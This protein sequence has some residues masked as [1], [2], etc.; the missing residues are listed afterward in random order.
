MRDARSS[1][2]W[3]ATGLLL[4]IAVVALFHFGVIVALRLSNSSSSTDMQSSSAALVQLHRHLGDPGDAW[5]EPIELNAAC[6][7]VS[8]L[9]LM[10]LIAGVAAG[11]SRQLRMRSRKGVGVRPNAGIARSWDLRKFCVRRPTLGRLTIG[12]VG[13][14]LLATEPQTS[15]AVIGPTG[16]GKTAGFAIPALLE[17]SGPIIATSV[18]TDLIDA[19][20]GHR[21]N[22][23]KVFV[24]DPTS[25]TALTAA[26]WS[27]LHSCETWA[28]AQQMAAW[29]CEAAQSRLDTLSDGDYWYAQARKALAPYLFAAAIGGASMADIAAWIDNQEEERVAAILRNASSTDASLQQVANSAEYRLRLAAIEKEVSVDVVA[30]MRRWFETAEPH[31]RKFAKQEPS[32]WPTVF[33]A[34]MQERVAEESRA[35]AQEDAESTLAASNAHR[36]H[37]MPLTSLRSLWGKDQRLRDSV[38][39]TVE[40]VVAPYAQLHQPPADAERIN[41]SEW[42]SGNNTIYVVA[43]SHEQARLRPV[44]TTFVQQAVRAA[45]DKAIKNGGL[46]PLPCLTLLD[47]AGN[48]APLR[49]LPSYASTARSHNISLVTVWQDLAQIRSIYRDRAQTVLNNHRAKLFGSGIADDHTLEYVSKLIGD[50]PHKER[51]TSRDASGSQRTISEHTSFRRAAPID[52]LRRMDRSQ[53]LLVYGAE[54]PALVKLRPWYETKI[55]YF[56]RRRF[57]H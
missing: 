57:W 36:E 8:E 43:S 5:V 14:R 25:C 3:I 56:N 18:K 4:L 52:E 19:T 17:W 49:D 11:T 9:C 38:F 44:L 33:Q 15:L 16:C 7:W 53:A 54:L 13:R 22:V 39:A 45:F 55:S 41:F 12:R 42:L 6:F 48:I 40:N 29:M 24:F 27:P 51:N 23:G 10:A 26:E 1:E 20:I 34:Q 46:L 37:L 30:E 2:E 50:V 31:F 47:E 21:R 28:G 32:E 35:I